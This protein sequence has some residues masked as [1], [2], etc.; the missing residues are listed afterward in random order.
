[1]VTD[2]MHGVVHAVVRAEQCMERFVQSLQHVRSDTRAV[3][4]GPRL[5]VQILSTVRQKER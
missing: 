1:M 5:D 4:H 2:R 3:D